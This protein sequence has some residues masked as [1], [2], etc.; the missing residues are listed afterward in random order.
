MTTEPIQE[1]F[2]ASSVQTEP[3]SAK[4]VEY[5]LRFAGLDIERTYPHLT[6]LLP[7]FFAF[8]L[9]QLPDMAV[10]HGWDRGAAAVEPFTGDDLRGELVN[11]FRRCFV[12]PKAL[13]VGRT[14][15]ALLVA[16]ARVAYA[17]SALADLENAPGYS[18][19]D[20]R[21]VRLPHAAFRTAIEEQFRR[22]LPIAEAESLALWPMRCPRARAAGVAYFEALGIPYPHAAVA[23]QGAS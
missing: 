23:E 7:T 18:R 2:P 22:E 21:V 3:L 14:V 5:A 6:F 17:V 15:D 13:P 8:V 11:R 12:G 4:L 1:S 9:A 16:R 19:A 20:R 10:R